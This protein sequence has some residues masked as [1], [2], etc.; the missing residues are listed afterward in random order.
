[1]P[2]SA[3]FIAPDT[4]RIVV[5]KRRLPTS[6]TEKYF[7]RMYPGSEV[8]GIV[9]RLKGKEV[10]RITPIYFFRL[11]VPKD[12]SLG[13][14]T[15]IKRLEDTTARAV[16]LVDSFKR[17]LYIVYFPEKEEAGQTFTLQFVE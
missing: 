7:L 14:Y 15:G 3:E 4:V 17:Y 2:V 10:R 8:A 9:K 6:K 16:F 12:V 11:D 1:K 13:R 5:P